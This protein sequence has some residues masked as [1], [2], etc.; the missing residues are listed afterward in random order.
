MQ[1]KVFSSL[2]IGILFLL[3]ILYFLEIKGEATNFLYSDYGKF[4]ASAH[5]AAK[6]ESL[7]SSIFFKEPKKNDPLSQTTVHRLPGNLNPPFFEFILYP[8]T[9]LSYKA[10]LIT[11]LIFG[12]MCGIISA[13]LTSAILKIQQPILI[14][15]LLVGLFAYYP[16]LI[17]I[18]F[19]QVSLL[20]LPLIISAWWAARNKNW[21]ILGITLGIAVNIKLFFGLF[22]LYFLLRRE[23]RALLW[24]CFA[25]IVCAVLPLLIF[26]LKNYL[27]YHLTLH[28]IW[29]YTSSWNASLF[30]FLLRL[31]GGDNEKNIPLAF[32]PTLSHFLYWSISLLIVACLSI[33]LRQSSKIDPQTK[34]DLDFSMTLVCM[35]LLA[36]LS[37]LYYFIFLLIPFCVL[38][39]LIEKDRLSLGFRLLT[40]FTVIISSLPFPLTL[41]SDIKYA[42]TIFLGCGVYFYALVL[43]FG[44]IFSAKVY[45]ANDKNY[46]KQKSTVEIPAHLIFLLYTMAL[47]PSLI[48]MSGIAHTLLKDTSRYMQQ[49]IIVN[50]T[51]YDISHT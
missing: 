40:C 14:L 43:L 20:L 11:W 6:N 41:P 25:S 29:W 44:L 3:S 26:N 36:P 4:Y 24:F 30:G 35:L 46:L 50:P 21:E 39:N 5:F 45:L 2:L 8:L 38:F 31:F 48:G 42:N 49:M 28:H 12:I 7:Y 18:Q 1:T 51:L 34:C 13:L 19:G 33:F 23:W 37:W 16:T 32:L 22:V 9:L 47:L 10:S 15:G 27:D 17:T